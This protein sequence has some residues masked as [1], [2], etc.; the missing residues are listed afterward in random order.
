MAGAR[1][2]IVRVQAAKRHLLVDGHN[3]L[4][5]WGWVSKHDMAVDRERLVEALRIVHDVEGA[6]VTVVFDG[7]GPAASMDV[8]AAAGFV[9]CY[10][11]AAL[12]ADGEIERLVARDAAHPERCTVVTGDNAVRGNVLAAG[13]EC[14]SPAELQAWIQRCAAR[15]RRKNVARNAAAQSGFSNRLPL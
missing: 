5:A 4:H 15:A 9:V 1:R 8:D 3:V 10:A 6:D 13:G 11:S 2:E 14:L 7:R 12:T